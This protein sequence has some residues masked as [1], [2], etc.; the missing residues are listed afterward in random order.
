MQVRIPQAPEVEDKRANL[1]CAVD[2]LKTV[3]KEDGDYILAP[4]P[5]GT[6]AAK[7]LI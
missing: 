4:R 3:A 5:F 6:H 2:A 1:R 7:S